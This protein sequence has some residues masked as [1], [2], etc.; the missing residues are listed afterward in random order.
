VCRSISVVLRFMFI[1]GPEEKNDEGPK[2]KQLNQSY[3]L[4][5]VIL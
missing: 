5:I 1:L 3:I 4:S 2:E